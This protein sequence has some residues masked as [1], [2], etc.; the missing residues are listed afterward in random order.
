[1]RTCLYVDNKGI[2]INVKYPFTVLETIFYN[3]IH[4]DDIQS[5]YSKSPHNKKKNVEFCEEF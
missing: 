2:F 3:F 4:F 5:N 1:M